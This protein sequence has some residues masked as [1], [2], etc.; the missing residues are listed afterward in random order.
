M[1]DP[2]KSWKLV[3]E[4]HSKDPWFCVSLPLNQPTDLTTP[5]LWKTEDP[6]LKAIEQTWAQFQE[7]QG[8]GRP[9]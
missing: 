4:N 9:C 8:L 3:G 7:V 1:L 2:W 5:N 6:A